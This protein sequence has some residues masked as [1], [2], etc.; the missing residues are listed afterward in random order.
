MFKRLLSLEWKAFFRSA[1]LGK[2]LGLKVLM[3]FI[4]LYFTVIFLLAGI[5][6]YPLIKN[7]MPGED[8][9]FVVNRLVLVWFLVELALRFFLQ[10][11]PVFDIKPLLN[12]PV[13]KR[14]IV[15]FV[16]FKSV[17]SFFN[18][19]PLLLIIP[20]GVFNI[21]ESDHSTGSI[22]AW[23]ATMTGLSLCMNFVNFIIKKQF[24]LNIKNLL[25]A[26]LFVV[27]FVV[28]DFFQIFETRQWFGR[29]LDLV[30]IYPIL[31]LVPLGFF[32]LLFFWNQYHLENNFYL[33][34][35]LKE[36]TTSVDTKEFLWTR[37]FG[38]LAP[39]MQQDMKLIW[40]NKR[41]KTAVYMSILLLG[42]GLIFYP[43]DFYSS[44]PAFFVFVGIFMT[45]V[46]MMNFGQFIPAWDAGYFPLIMSQNISMERY[47]SAKAG[48]I[49]LSVVALAVLTT[50]Y[51]YFGWDIFLINIICAIYN[52]GVNIPILLYAGSYNRK[53]IDLDKSPFMNFQGIGVAQWLVA[54]PLMVIPVFIFW[55]FNKVLIFEGS[56]LLLLCLGLTGLALRK[57]TID[58]IAEVYKKNKY[59]MIEGFK[60]EGE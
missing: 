4:A 27:V 37:W 16:L 39:Y 12:L 35:G 21:F 48:L 31:S 23:M 33:D 52:I 56:A 47:L 43:Q 6:L 15:N 18:F 1:S 54:I 11:L 42:Y 46:F 59:A 29:G 60:Q 55:I 24:T 9:L 8:P 13:R 44:M 25:P 7:H 51:L 22:L 38:D 19:L 26:L 41:P 50:P 40:R 5:G 45:G 28:L 36:R 53:R 17:F 58:F 3:T 30:L 20:F 34:A 32:V 2:S 14:N 10:A 57:T 49:T